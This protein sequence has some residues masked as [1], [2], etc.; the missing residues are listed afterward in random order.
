MAKVKDDNKTGNN[1][2]FDHLSCND[3][4]SENEKLLDTGMENWLNVLVFQEMKLRRRNLSASK[5]MKIH[6]PAVN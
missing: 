1:F 2:M 5:K 3:Y 6:G 4:Y